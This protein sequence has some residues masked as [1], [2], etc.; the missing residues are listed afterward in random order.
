MRIARARA[1]VCFTAKQERF[2]NN[3]DALEK[4]GIDRVTN[5]TINLSII[6]ENRV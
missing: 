6:E 1:L 4:L 3:V 5:R 2:E